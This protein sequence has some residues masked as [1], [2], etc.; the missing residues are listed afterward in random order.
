MREET[1]VIDT[2]TLIEIDKK[3]PC[4]KQI[5]DKLPA[6]ERKVFA[7]ILELGSGTSAEIAIVSRI[8]SGLASAF[9][10]RLV[11]RGL[12]LVVTEGSKKIYSITDPD[13]ASL[14][15]LRHR[16]G[17]QNTSQGK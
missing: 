12:V 9:L 1:R 3:T 10:G 13:F 17:W 11:K 5:M 14:Y 15:R 16:Q 4:F 6:K 2:S 8:S 7:G